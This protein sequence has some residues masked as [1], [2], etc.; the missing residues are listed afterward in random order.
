MI[1]QV[2]LLKY[3]ITQNLGNAARMCTTTPA[4][5]TRTFFPH[6]ALI[7]K[8]RPGDEARGSAAVSS[9][10]IVED[11]SVQQCFDSC[12]ELVRCMYECRCMLC[13]CVC[14]CVC[15]CMC[16][17][18]HCRTAGRLESSLCLEDVSLPTMLGVCVLCC[19]C[20]CMYV[21]SM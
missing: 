4:M 9:T 3:T 21:Y 16:V 10:P 2:I 13:V 11:Q 17:T 14:V 7:E 18:T 8:K 1:L 5:D 19:V 6:S 15:V 12:M 20:V